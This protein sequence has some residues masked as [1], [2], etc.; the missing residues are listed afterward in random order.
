MKKFLLALIAI[1]FIGCAAG[2][3]STESLF[4]PPLPQTPKLQFLTSISDEADL[5]TKPGGLAEYLYGELAS[6]KS[7]ARP[8][9][10]AAS[11]GKIYL[12]DKTY[13]KILYMDLEKKE[14]NFIND[15]GDGEI[16]QP[17]GIWVTEDDYKYVVDN[18]RR[19]VLLYNDNND[20]VK[21]YGD[22]TI[23][24]RPT[25]VAVYKDNV[26]VSDV[27][28]NKVFVLDRNSGEVIREIGTKL[29]KI[30]G[31]FNKPAYL[32]VDKKGN[33]YVTDS[34]N[35]RIQIFDPDGTLI[36]VI[37]KAGDTIG[38]FAR[39]K[40]VA[41]DSKGYMYVVDAA[42]SNVQ[43]FDIES[44]DIVLFFGG[45]NTGALSMYLPQSIYIDFENIEYFQEFIDPDFKVEYLIYVGSSAGYN[46]ISIYAFGEWTGSAR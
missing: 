31:E 25:G 43:I 23:F 29:S 33:L 45:V 17:F 44:T 1:T 9:S 6:T 2:K 16:S 19:Q 38:S 3:K 14:L 30:E 15:K 40:G 5:G 13:N 8:V 34:F 28:K 4:I 37:G 39:P 7:I 32:T 10:I 24:E 12:S 18:G 20:Y 11:K 42:F 22:E 46:K 41:V 36:K 26:Y 35:F 27:R 21:A